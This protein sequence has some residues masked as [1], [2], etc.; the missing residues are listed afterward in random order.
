MPK[1]F[2]LS[3]GSKRKGEDP[4]PYVSVAEQIEQFQ[5]RTPARYPLRSR[6][7]QERGM[8]VYI[9][10]LICFYFKMVVELFKMSICNVS[11]SAAPLNPWQAQPL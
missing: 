9:F 11:F 3:T 7:R 10:Y 1:P 2:N 6:M 4:A 5:K 8:H